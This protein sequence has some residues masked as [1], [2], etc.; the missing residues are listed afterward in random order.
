MGCGKAATYSQVSAHLSFHPGS[1]RK[2]DQAKELPLL[3]LIPE[4]E[5]ISVLFQ[6]AA[7]ETRGGP[8]Q[9][10]RAVQLDGAAQ[11]EAVRSGQTVVMF[12][13]H[14]AVSVGQWSKWKSPCVE[15]LE[16]CWG[17]QEGSSLSL[18]CGLS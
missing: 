1:D 17:P 8:C 12:Q 4:G 14:A 11:T 13:P 9:K 6:A 2:F 5:L 10:T 7:P 15:T 18:L 3:E 16:V